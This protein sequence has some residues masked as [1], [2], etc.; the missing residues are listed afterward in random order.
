MKITLYV[1]EYNGIHAA[2]VP[3]RAYAYPWEPPEWTTR[4]V[5]VIAPDGY[6]VVD[7]VWRHPVLLD[8]V[9]VEAELIPVDG[10]IDAIAGRGIVHLPFAAQPATATV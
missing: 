1:A 9:G 6:S 4:A 10:G 5:Q 3:A 7:G 2:S 8:D